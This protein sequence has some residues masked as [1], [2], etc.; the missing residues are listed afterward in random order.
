MVDESM[1]H[2]LSGGKNVIVAIGMG[3]FSSNKSRHV[4]FIRYLI[5]KLRPLGYT[6]V[7]VN[8][9][10]TS[11]KCPCC[12]EFVETI[13]DGAEFGLRWPDTTNPG[14]P[15]GAYLSNPSKC[16][17]HAESTLA[18][19]L[20]KSIIE[21]SM[22][23]MLALSSLI[24]LV[25]LS[26]SAIAETCT[27][28]VDGQ[29]V[30]P[31]HLLPGCTHNI[32]VRTGDTINGIA[33]AYG[34]PGAQSLV[35]LN[36]GLDLGL[37]VYP[38]NRLC[39]CG[40]AELACPKPPPSCNKFYKVKSGDTC[41]NI[42]VS[43]DY[44]GSDPAAKLVALNKE[45]DIGI[46]CTNLQPGANICVDCFLGQPTPIKPSEGP[47]RSKEPAG[48]GAPATGAPFPSGLASPILPSP[49]LAKPSP[50]A[51]LGGNSTGGNNGGG[52]TNPTTTSTRKGQ[53]KVT[54][55]ATALNG[56]ASSVPSATRAIIP[57]TALNGE[58]SNAPTAPKA[59]NTNAAQVPK[60]DATAATHPTGSTLAG[61]NGAPAANARSHGFKR[62]S[63]AA[64]VS[65]LLLGAAT[66]KLLF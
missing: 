23:K 53:P 17:Q 14:A 55:P 61:T 3:D 58:A 24:F 33:S 63:S 18:A 45:M 32:T 34:W 46:D 1:G 48:G 30:C 7:G 57:A 27:S 62:S 15:P 40:P 43:Y 47:M 8:E 49:E 11:K 50:D 19:H 9:Y 20:F 36:P 66:V 44:Q 5:R 42:A 56:E 21:I 28:Q 10:F 2:T 64:Y 16:R 38:G 25:T 65:F 12:Q 51:H 52:N 35:P 60:A 13:W 39:V 54:I 26:T 22:S 41:F 6:I 4:M 31:F 29:S 59:D 37:S